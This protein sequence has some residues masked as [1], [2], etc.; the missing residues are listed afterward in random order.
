MEPVPNRDFLLDY[1]NN[2]NTINSR[3]IINYYNNYNMLNISVWN[4]A[5]REN[6]DLIHNIYMNHLNNNY[7][8]N[9]GQAAAHPAE[10]VEPVTVA[11]ALSTFERFNLDV[12]LVSLVSQEENQDSEDAW[13]C[14]ICCENSEEE[15]IKEERVITKCNHT[16]H[17][18]CLKRWVVQKTTC[19]MC[20]ASLK[21]N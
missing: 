13:L 1:I 2:R 11:S 7:I 20:R 12:S 16:F 6:I 21:K 4:R 10:A 9:H 15:E 3:N 19:P 8:Y 14:S 17:S 5:E 18:K